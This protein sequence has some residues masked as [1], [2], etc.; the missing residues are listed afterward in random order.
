MRKLLEALVAV[1]LVLPAS[2]SSA[3]ADR[4]DGELTIIVSI[5]PQKYFVERIAGENADVKVLI[6]PGASPAAWELS[7]SDMRSVAGADIW[8]T[9]GVTSELGWYDDFQE[10]N[11]ELSVV[12]ALGTIE[13]LP[14][15]RYGIYGVSSEHDDS[16]G[17]HGGPDPHVWLSPELV[18]E[19]AEVIA[20][21]LSGMDPGREAVYS[22]S[23]NSFL[24]DITDLQSRLHRLLDDHEGAAF[25]VFHPAWGYFA[26]EFG[27]IQVPIESAGSE[28]SPGEMAAIVDLGLARG[29]SVIFVS[30]QFSS[31]SAETI[32]GELGA[33]V[34]VID[35]LAEDWMSNMDSVSVKLQE[36]LR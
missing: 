35:P 23:L 28:P 17:D 15:D 6:P 14:I 20:S 9:A 2:C 25:M 5:L 10:L 12:S 13:R 8:F 7:P 32:A 19:Q 29:V 16:H 22:D 3:G 36:A 24:D 21:T 1:L 11:P 31:S 18:R 27:L 4:T 34:A 30:P 33:A 26:D